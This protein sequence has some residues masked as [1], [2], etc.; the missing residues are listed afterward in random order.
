[1]ESCVI[2][3]KILKYCWRMFLSVFIEKHKRIVLD[4]LSFKECSLHSCTMSSNS[5]M[6]Y[7]VFTM[8]SLMCKRLYKYIRRHYLENLKTVMSF[9]RN[10][11]D[12]RARSVFMEL[13]ECLV[14]ETWDLN[15]NFIK[16]DDIYCEFSY[17][18]ESMDLEKDQYK[19]N[20]CLWIMNIS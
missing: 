13:K 6:I 7:A 17:P 18:L 14:A 4:K 12:F 10:Q 19:E 5:V 2:I 15:E 11:N 9:W 3:F 1:M 20:K 8:T 16:W